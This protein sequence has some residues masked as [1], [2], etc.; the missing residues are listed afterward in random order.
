M[1]RKGRAI[2]FTMVFVKLCYARGVAEGGRLL[3]EADGTKV[4]LRSLVAEARDAEKTAEEG[5]QRTNAVVGDLSSHASSAK[6]RIE[7][8]RGL[9]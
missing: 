5:L 3:A 1:P 7:T 2:E 9:T 6:A 4:R 8:L